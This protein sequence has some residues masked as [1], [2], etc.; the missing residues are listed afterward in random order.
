MFRSRAEHRSQGQTRWPKEMTTEFSSSRPGNPDPRHH[1]KL[2][3]ALVVFLTLGQLA[4]TVFVPRSFSL[5]LINDVIEFLLILSATVVFLVNASASP[6]QTRLF[7]MLLAACWGARTI[8]QVVW[9]YFD[10]VLRREV[11]NPFVGDILLFLSSIPFL[12][13]LLLQPH[14]YP[15]ED[16][17][18]PGHVGFLLLLLWWLYLYMILVIPWQYVVLDE[19]RYGENYERLNGLLAVVMLLTLGF[20]WR[21]GFESWKCFYASLF[22]A[23]LLMT[24]A[25]YL[26]NHAINEHT[27]YPG[28]WYDLPYTVAVASFTVV[29]FLGLTLQSTAA[30]SEEPRAGLHV[31]ELGMLAVLSLPVI[32]AWAVLNRNTPS[33]VNQFRGLVTLGTMLVM[34]FLVFAKQRQLKAELTKANQGLQEASLTD[35]LTGVRNRR[36]FEAIV[37]GDASQVLRSYSEPRKPGANDLIFYLVDLDNF[38]EVND[39]YGHDIGDK[40][41]V[42][43]IRQINSVIRSSD[44]VVRWGGDEFLIV[45][46]YSNRAEAATFASRILTAVA[47]PTVGLASA[48]IEIRQTCSIG[49]AAFPWYPDRPDEVPLETVL[50]LAD[51]GVYEA[52]EGGK[53]RA[54]GVLPSDTGKVLLTDTPG[55]RDSSYSG[56]MV[57]VEGPSEF[58]EPYHAKADGRDQVVVAPEAQQVMSA[59]MP[60]AVDRIIAETAASEELRRLFDGHPTPMWVYDPETLRFLDVNQAAIL[61]YGYSRAEFL[62]LTILDIQPTADI[63][64]LLHEV[65]RRPLKGPSTAVWRHRSKDGTVFNVKTT[66]HEVTVRGRV[67]ELV[68]AVRVSQRNDGP[69]EANRVLHELRRLSEQGRSVAKRHPLIG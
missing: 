12:A 55:A 23:Q 2:W 32:G 58:L 31:A 50:K 40:V 1:L 3:A 22:G 49:W 52:K 8:C 56:Q 57:C 7:W 34:A 11:P 59:S 15:V 26:A 48:G 44:V 16:R 67:A 54:I 24:V 64:L 47:N 18:S 61:G 19:A 53:N 9:M 5:T 46:R 63:P 17:K 4:A 14:L 39:R 66:R 30:T 6:R 28:S 25:G 20:L 10:I 69:S 38:K 43:V 41:L 68:D 13:A 29:G 42:K 62:G 36:F 35:P 51:R 21:R 65:L 45:S 33:Q 60:A 37:P 27:Y